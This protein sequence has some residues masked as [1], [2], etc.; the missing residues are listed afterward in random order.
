MSATPPEQSP[1]T[2]KALASID[3]TADEAPIQTFGRITIG[4]VLT[5]VGAAIALAFFAAYLVGWAIP[6]IA[7]WVDLLGDVLLW[8]AAVGLGLAITGFTLLRRGRK[9]RAAEA[10]E[11][12]AFISSGGLDAARA[13]AAAQT[14]SVK[15]A[16]PPRET[17]L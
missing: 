4:I 8:I 16:G 12:A 13:E 15:D 5:I 7:D 1:E 11:A 14:P 6:A 2:V 17:H 3:L 10:A 9:A